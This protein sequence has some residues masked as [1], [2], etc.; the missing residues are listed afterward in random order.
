MP[1]IARD[2]RVAV[3][4]LLKSPGF[5]L[6]AILTLAL[7]IGATVSIF[8]LV[9]AILLR[10]LPFP[11]PDRLVLLGDHVGSG[12]G[13]GITAREIR[14][15]STAARA[16]SSIGGFAGASF[17]LS[18]GAVPEQI[19]AAR[20]TASVFPT[21]GVQPVLGRVFTPQED[22]AH[23]PVAVISDSLWL[24]RYHRD[25]HI[26]GTAIVLD[27]RAYSIIGVMPS[28]FEFPLRAGRLDQ[29]QL[30]VPM[31]LTP[32]ELSDENAGHWGYNL[33]ARLR[34]G[35]TV[36]QAAQDANR[37]AQQVM[38]E[39][40]AN[41]VAIHIR[42]DVRLLRD[43]FVADSRPL[44]RTLLFAVLVVLL[45]ACANV[46]GLL[47]VRALRRRHEYA[48]HVALGAQPGVILRESL[49]EGLLLGVAGGAVG[50]ALAAVAIRATLHL[51]PESLPR[52]DAVS[53]NGVVVLFALFLAL[54]TGALSSV[55]P[56]FV[57]LRTN[58]VES[59]REGTRTGTGTA[60]HAW[61]HS[62][63]VVAEIAIALVLLTTSGLLLRSYQRMLAVNP[64][65]TPSNVLVAE[66]QL[67]LRQYP[68]QSAAD[69][70]NRA[71]IDRL[72]AKPGVAFAG[73]TNYLPAIDDGGAAA[74]TVGGRPAA[75]WK[76]TFARFAVTYGDYFRALDIPLLAGRTFTT[77]DRAGAPLVVIVNQS[78]AKHCWPGESAIGKQ[79]HVGN[80]Q[81]GLPWAT[82]VGVVA[83][84]TPGGRDQPS[85]DQWYIP[86][87][88]PSILYGTVAS[89]PLTN[90][91]GGYITLRSTLP[92]EQ[93]EPT[94]RS[95]IAAVDPL[96]AIDQVRTMN[97]VLANTE[98]P[99]RFNTGLMSAFAA[100]ALLLAL[101]GI[102][103]VVAFSV[104][105]RTQ[106]IAIRMAL[107]ARRT[108]IARLVIAA[109]LRLAFIGC[110]I[111]VLASLA[112]GR[113][114]SS[115]LFE[116]S[117]IDP[118]VY[119]SAIAAMI[120]L[121]VLGAAVPANRA[122]ASD[123]LET[124]RTA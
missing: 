73:I 8:S 71:V 109:A 69:T 52:V 53:I 78:M 6:T 9:D 123:P 74:Y 1:A 39:F 28:S 103:A 61:L 88:Q 22:E 100:A 110:G 65:Y 21:L 30:W 2:L 80:P 93:M 33:V 99:R 43:Q 76:L 104:T 54:V 16:F 42:G 46:S 66:Y 124:L 89:S 48:V 13:L 44:L 15:Y 101:T 115:F 81:K 41:M 112:V 122:A 56:A 45:I 121:A 50:L 106:E 68:T 34:D 24:S 29:A 10:P 4:R 51:L 60:S 113:L 38:R 87:E 118:V 49:L 59:L 62:S 116:V 58:L 36:P 20:L 23:Q 31:S 67:P 95:A 102:Y 119:T 90:P 111:G 114:V 27:R 26:L 85:A 37:V 11:N 32:D 96:L 40:P 47:L 82:V 5:N 70:F 35:V 14:T 18:G 3:R 117:P 98:A 108:S 105:L 63:L 64:G 57:A 86:A 107:G 17:E 77:D 92:P 12:T 79:I 25:P 91:A 55:V 19:D 72:T 75:A 84:T 120:L 83:D 7:G 97:E 94:L